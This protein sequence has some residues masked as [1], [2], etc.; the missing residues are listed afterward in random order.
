MAHKSLL[1]KQTPSVQRE[2]FTLCGKDTESPLHGQSELHACVSV[3]QGVTG[4]AA[5]GFEH[6]SKAIGKPVSVWL[7]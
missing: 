3:T 6:R 5:A 7:P 4:D 1:E 2:L